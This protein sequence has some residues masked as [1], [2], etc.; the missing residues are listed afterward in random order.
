MDNLTDSLDKKLRER[1]QD[2][3][4]NPPPG[5]WGK[6]QASGIPLGA[7]GWWPGVSRLWIPAAAVLAG[8]S[9]LLWI[10]ID[11]SD[12]GQ[13]EYTWRDTFFHLDEP[14]MVQQGSGEV[15]MPYDHKGSREEDQQAEMTAP[16]K[17]RELPET[18]ALPAKKTPEEIIRHSPVE[19]SPEPLIAIAHRMTGLLEKRTPLPPE[20]HIK[21]TWTGEDPHMKAPL[22]T[23]METPVTDKARYFHKSPF[24]LGLS[25]NGSRIFNTLDTRDKAIYESGLT[26]E[27]RYYSPNNYFF[28]TGVG[29]YQTKDS[30]DY[31]IDFQ[32]PQFL[33]HYTAVDSVSYI[34]VTGSAGQ[35]SIVITYHTHQEEVYDTVNL[36][37]ES[38]TTKRYT[39]LTIPLMTGYSG[40][41]NRFVYS[42]STGII[43]SVLIHEKLWYDHEG[44]RYSNVLDIQDYRHSRVST[45]WH[46]VLSAGAGYQISHRWTAMVEPNL[47]VYFNHLYEGNNLSSSVKRPFS[48]GLNAGIYYR[49]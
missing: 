39:Y 29:V 48:A 9:V 30:W 42:L 43:I 19:K 35:D 14:D 40:T 1:F 18:E 22:T 4:P 31:V 24:S 33:G 41:H 10:L 3:S 6:V 11:G 28:Q 46:Y 26:L 25:W 34:I 49:F 17:T 36:R 38:F 47:K 2:F 32:K 44:E 13:G 45:N 5:V 12:Q 7:A 20:L 23:Q 8:L 16:P 27:G 37:D 21:E 15:A